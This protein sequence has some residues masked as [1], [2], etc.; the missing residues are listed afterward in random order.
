MPLYIW[1]G[2]IE[3][4]KLDRY[5]KIGTAELK[6]EGGNIFAD[7][8]ILEFDKGKVSFAANSP[9]AALGIK[10]IDVSSAGPRID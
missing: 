3:G 1:A 6:P 7:P 4:N 10:P 9:I 2:K 5:S 8:Q